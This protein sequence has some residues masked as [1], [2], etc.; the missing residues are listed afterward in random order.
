MILTKEN[1]KVGDKVYFYKNL[2]NVGKTVATITHI[3][4]DKPVFVLQLDNG[5]FVKN[6]LFGYNW[7][8]VDDM[9]WVIFQ[10]P[11]MGATKSC[12]QCGKNNNVDVSVCWNCA[13]VDP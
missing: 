4:L 1:A 11:T 12:H 5:E 8:M 7:T 13:V 9:P 10:D 6:C 2:G 3:D